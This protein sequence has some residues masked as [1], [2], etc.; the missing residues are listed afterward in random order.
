MANQGLYG[1]LR[2]LQQEQSLQEDDAVSAANVVP[3]RDPNFRQLSRAPFV[4]RLQTIAQALE[5]PDDEF[6]APS[7]SPATLTPLPVRFRSGSIGL[8]F[9]GQP[10][11]A[12]P[13]SGSP[14]GAAE[15]WKVI[16]PLWEIYR[17]SR[18]SGRPPAPSPSDRPEAL[19][20][21]PLDELDERKDANPPV[22]PIDEL[23]QEG[24]KK[25][26]SKIKSPNIV[27]DLPD[28]A[29]DPSD[30]DTSRPSANDADCEKEEQEAIAF[31]MKAKRNG[32]KGPFGM[33]HIA[34]PRNRD[35]D[36]RFQKCVKGQMSP[37]C[38]G[39]PIK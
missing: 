4:E 11:S 1:L 20:E 9:P 35:W 5:Q 32:W 6:G 17:G 37:R 39:S 29:S 26:P 3:S 38:G 31:C 22:D 12:P 16:K 36:R 33:N 7:T 18:P 19:R 34:E 14:P 15:L 21:R 8:P 24:R 28:E 13:N 30:E 27:P 10:P 23:R 25:A 2:A